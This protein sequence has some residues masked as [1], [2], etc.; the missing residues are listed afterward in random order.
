[1]TGEKVCY[2]L[3]LRDSPKENR[4][5]GLLPVSADASQQAVFIEAEGCVSRDDDVVQEFY[6]KHLT[7]VSKARGEVFIFR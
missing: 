3:P 5:T 1:M 2:P 6:S 7:G 4:R